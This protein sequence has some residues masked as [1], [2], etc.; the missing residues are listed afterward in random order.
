MFLIVSE[1]LDLL[2]PCSIGLHLSLRTQTQAPGVTKYRQ[3]GKAPFLPTVKFLTSFYWVHLKD[4]QFS[5]S[6]SLIFLPSPALQPNRPLCLSWLLVAGACGVLNEKRHLPP[7]LHS[8][9]QSHVWR[10]LG[11]AA[12]LEE[13]CP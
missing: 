1:L 9:P 11:S 13:V 7:P 8:P 2:W 12:L 6:D 10:G 4:S 5:I 3:D